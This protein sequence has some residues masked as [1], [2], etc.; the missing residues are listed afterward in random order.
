MLSENK[1]SE[2][3]EQMRTIQ[4]DTVRGQSS[5]QQEKLQLENAYQQAQRRIEELDNSLRQQQLL[6][7]ELSTL[8]QQSNGELV[9][10][11]ATLKQQVT[12]SC[13]G[14]SPYLICMYPVFGPITFCITCHVSCVMHDVS[15]MYHV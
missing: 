7:N 14:L 10:E 15:F 5:W 12:L 4:Q 9:Q 2:L 1:K 8:K 11:L 3:L 6:V 13:S